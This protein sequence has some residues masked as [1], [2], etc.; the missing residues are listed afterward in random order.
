MTWRGSV[1][2]RR[3]A[4]RYTFDLDTSALECERQRIACLNAWRGA[5]GQPP[6][7][8]PAERRV[9]PAPGATMLPLLQTLAGPGDG[10]ERADAEKTVTKLGLSALAP[11]RAFEAALPADAPRRARLE[12]LEHQLACTV[13]GAE[14]EE[15]PVDDEEWRLAAWK[16]LDALVGMPLTPEGFFAL[17]SEIA[18]D[19]P[20]GAAGFVLEAARDEDLSGVR[21]FLKLRVPRRYSA[22]ARYNGTNEYVSLGHEALHGLS[23]SRRWRGEENH[24][25]FERAADRA[26]EAAADRPFSLIISAVGRD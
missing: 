10:A 16:R 26:L 17:A 1:L 12:T 20:A 5:H 7:P 11:L 14:L 3:F 19:L 23:G 22:Y 25:T 15:S 2:A 24:K 21:L 13:A 4:D 9:E 18:D 8:P 6:L